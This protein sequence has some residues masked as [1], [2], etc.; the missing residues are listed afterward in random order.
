MARVYALILVGALPLCLGMEDATT[1]LQQSTMDRATPCPDL[2]KVTSYGGAG[3]NAYVLRFNKACGPVKAGSVAKAFQSTEEAKEA[4]DALARLPKVKALAGLAA[5]TT[6]F[7]GPCVNVDPSADCCEAWKVS[8]TCHFMVMENGGAKTLEQCAEGD[9]NFHPLRLK[10]L[11]V[12]AIDAALAIHRLGWYHS[13]YQL[14]N[15]MADDKCDPPSLKVVD[16]DTMDDADK[17]AGQYWNKPHRMFSDY[18]KL[19]GTC[20]MGAFQLDA[21]QYKSAKAKEM[22]GKIQNKVEPIMNPHCGDSHQMT[23]EQI[24]A[25]GQELKK[26]VESAK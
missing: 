20:D 1:L 14:K 3:G 7:D 21:F 19:L 10:G 15:I 6:E 25:L 23:T 24:I 2:A 9:A 18:A 11:V 17:G 16:L 12:A 8:D 22:A 4:V 26:A 13:D 5:G